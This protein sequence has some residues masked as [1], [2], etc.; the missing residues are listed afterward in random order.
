MAIVTGKPACGL[1]LITPEDEAFYF[2][3]R[4]GIAKMLNEAD[5]PWDNRL[6]MLTTNLGGLLAVIG[7]IPDAERDDALEK[8]IMNVRIGYAANRG[9]PMARN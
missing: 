2:K 8:A 5:I 3:I 9:P 6:M 4:D 1:T 7:V